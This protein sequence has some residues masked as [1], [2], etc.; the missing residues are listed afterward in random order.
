VKVF[1]QSKGV[2]MWTKMRGAHR[3]KRPPRPI[4][5]MMPHQD[6][7]RRGRLVRLGTTDLIM[8]MDDATKE[9]NSAFLL[10]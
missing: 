1:L 4:P 8:T 9:L 2:L 7:S 6:G 10:L 3:H 5:G